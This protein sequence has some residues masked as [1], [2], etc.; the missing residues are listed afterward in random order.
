MDKSHI[1]QLTNNLYK[2][3]LF[4]P[5]KEPLRYK[6]REVAVNFLANPNKEDL[7]ALN[8]FFDVSLAQNWVSP[9]DILAIKEG[10]G[11]LSTLLDNEEMVPQQ[12][13]PQ[14]AS[15]EVGDLP[16]LDPI[17]KIQK[18]SN[19]HHQSALTERQEKI[20]TFL[21]E[22]NRAQVWQLKEVF[23]EVTKRTLRRDFESLLQNSKIERVG[24]KNDT[25]YQLKS[26]TS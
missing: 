24:E 3:T 16:I 18:T 9:S 1:I 20:I 8:D 22:N 4:F 2:V 7:S 11:N 6:L 23:P 14:I 10:Y 25:F 19:F 15:N 26:Y 5:K 12:T 21:K 17:R 13:L